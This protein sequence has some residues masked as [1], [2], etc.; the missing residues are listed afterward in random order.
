MIGRRMDADAQH[1]Q[2]QPGEHH[3]ADHSSE[4]SNGRGGPALA[5]G[6]ILGSLPRKRPQRS[7]PRRAAAQ[8]RTAAA[9][10]HTASTQATTSAQA[11]T[12]STQARTTSA[13]AREAEGRPA[14][15]AKRPSAR[16]SASAKKTAP[17][18][19]P[20]RREPPAPRQG[21]EPED[22]LELG[23]S[24]HP[25]SGVE[26]VESVADIFVELAS[27]GLK[28]GGRALKDALSPLHRS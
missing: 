11:R 26:L 22:E 10:A 20:R 6:G 12:A 25:P 5:D 3:K 15:A 16:R 4:R 17:P 27:A 28:A 1:E 21:Y 23:R 13:Q 9:Q 14:L 18:K 2:E 24:V 7:S 19:S 8:A